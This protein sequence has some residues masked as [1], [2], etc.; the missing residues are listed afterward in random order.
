VV[1]SAD[2]KPAA[3][4]FGVF[5]VC[6]LRLRVCVVTGAACVLLLWLVAPP[7]DQPG[8]CCVCPVLSQVSQA[9]FHF[10]C[11]V[12]C[13]SDSDA[14][15]AAASA[16][17]RVPWWQ[18]GT[19]GQRRVRCGAAAAVRVIRVLCVFATGLDIVIQ[20]RLNAVELL[21]DGA[22]PGHDNDGQARR[23]QTTGGAGKGTE[24]VLI[25]IHDSMHLF[26]TA[27]QVLGA[28]EDPV[29]VWL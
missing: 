29:N 26:A 19:A 24:P 1:S 20:L 21:R 28:L 4:L 17:S 3:C 8:L 23:S 13:D 27:R 5:P 10:I 16:S 11:V 2:L 18:A 15:C 25:N 6:K 12:C 9:T 14:R 7:S 22:A